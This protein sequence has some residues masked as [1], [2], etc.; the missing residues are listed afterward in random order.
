MSSSRKK[1]TVQ[2]SLE[3]R[4]DSEHPQAKKENNRQ[5]F[6]LH[7]SVS[8]KFLSEASRFSALLMTASL[9]SPTSLT[10]PQPFRLFAHLERGVLPRSNGR[11]KRRL[12]RANTRGGA[13]D[14]SSA[15]WPAQSIHL[16]SHLFLPKA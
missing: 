16:L 15:R 8:L 2:G 10:A 7:H 11:N 1:L 9:R 14:D 6:S 13:A 3:A 4:G 5:Q 12:Y